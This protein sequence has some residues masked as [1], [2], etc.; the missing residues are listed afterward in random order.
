[1]RIGGKGRGFE[2]FSHLPL[3]VLLG[4]TA[5]T[6]GPGEPPADPRWTEHL[7][8]CASCAELLRELEL[9]RDAAVQGDV[10]SAPKAWI[11]RA[12]KLARP[13]SMVTQP[14]GSFHADVVFDSATIEHPFGWATAGGFSF[15]TALKLRG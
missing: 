6:P 12:V 15:T 11:G 7:E 5:Q 4:L 14:A 9:M 3:E 10:G 2:D 8:T 1:M 13:P